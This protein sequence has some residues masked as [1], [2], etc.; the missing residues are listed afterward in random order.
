MYIFYINTPIHRPVKTEKCVL[1]KYKCQVL[2]TH[3]ICLPHSL[4]KR[5]LS[6]FPIERLKTC[7]DKTN[8]GITWAFL[9]LAHC[10]NGGA[11]LE[12]LWSH[13]NEDIGRIKSESLTVAMLVC[14]LSL[15][16][17]ISPVFCPGED[18]YIRLYGSCEEVDVRLE[19]DLVRLTPTYLS[20]STVNRTVSLVNKHNVPLQYC[21]TTAGSMQ[22]E[23]LNFMRFVRTNWTI[24]PRLQENDRTRH[25][26]HGRKSTAT[27]NNRGETAKALTLNECAQ[28]YAGVLCRVLGRPFRTASIEDSATNMTRTVVILL[29]YLLNVLPSSLCS[30][31]Q[32]KL[33]VPAAWRARGEDEQLWSSR[34]TLSTAQSPAGFHKSSWSGSPLVFFTRLHHGGTSGWCLS[35]SDMQTCASFPSI[36]APVSEVSHC[37]VQRSKRVEE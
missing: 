11:L 24:Y 16:Q 35:H 27:K 21:W 7:V 20:L 30:N 34:K 13:R 5:L 3:C 12:R 36:V 10:Q 9:S 31:L 4:H 23:A 22:E 18:V 6:L 14:L 28:W 37:F 25:D 8:R 29:K 33:R 2:N 26:H 15:T 1:C 19:P 17:L 32:E